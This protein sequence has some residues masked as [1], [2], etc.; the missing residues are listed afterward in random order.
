MTFRSPYVDEIFSMTEIH[1]HILAAPDPWIWSKLMLIGHVQKCADP[2]AV[3][4][5][6]EYVGKPLADAS[7]F[8]ST[9]MLY[10]SAIVRHYGTASNSTLLELLPM[11]H[12]LAKVFGGDQLIISVYWIYMRKQYQLMPLALFNSPRVPYEF[13]RRMPNEPYII[14]AGNANRAVCKTRPTN[15]RKLLKLAGKYIKPAQAV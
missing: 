2:T 14:T 7:Y 8:M 6:E 9:L 10:D 3:L 11:Y 12:K 15:G 1:G 5:A 13:W 4:E